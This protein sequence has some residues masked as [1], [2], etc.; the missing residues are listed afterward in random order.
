MARAI[1]TTEAIAKGKVYAHNPIL[2]AGMA[3][4]AGTCWSTQCSMA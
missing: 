1:D 3:I 2:E 4:V